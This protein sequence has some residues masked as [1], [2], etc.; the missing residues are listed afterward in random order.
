MFSLVSD[1][2]FKWQHRLVLKCYLSKV[3]FA[4]I[5]CCRFWQSSF[6]TCHYDVINP[7]FVA[8]RRGRVASQQTQN[9]WRHNQWRPKSMTESIS[10]NY[11]FPIQQPVTSLHSYTRWAPYTLIAE[12]WC[13]FAE[14]CKPKSC[15]K[16]VVMWRTE[17]IEDFKTEPIDTGELRTNIISSHRKISRVIALAPSVYPHTAAGRTV[18]VRSQGTCL[19]TVKI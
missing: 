3:H 12:C 5:G 18:C 4:R 13:N 8:K 16:G 17:L 14:F 6:F 15:T 10:D 9:Q 19:V 1:I 7:A 2:G 11:K